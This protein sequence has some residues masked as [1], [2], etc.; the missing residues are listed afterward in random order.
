MTKI[1]YI[2]AVI[3]LVTVFLTGAIAGWIIK[4]GAKVNNQPA[5]TVAKVMVNPT[6]KEAKQAD[7]ALTVQSRGQLTG[8]VKITKQTG[9]DREISSHPEQ[10]VGVEDESSGLQQDSQVT[11]PVSGTITTTY[12]DDQ[13]GQTVGH[14][15]HAVTGQADVTVQD[16][17]ITADVTIDDTSQVAVI[18]KHEPRKNE[19]G[20]YVGVAACSDPYFYAGA[21]Y[22]RNFLTMQ[23]KK[24]DMAL[25]ARV[26]AERRWGAN[27]DWEGRIM[28]GVRVEW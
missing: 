21:Y 19:F 3:A 24:A 20:G 16:D 23:T 2:L 11:I 18:I 14:G 26:S 5:A 12:I 28:A 6:P 22:Q 27:E 1:K 9:S 17:T 7:V 8:S 4:P 25:F 13:T 10:A 15:S